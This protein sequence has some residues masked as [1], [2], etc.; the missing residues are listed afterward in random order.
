MLLEFV[1]VHAFNNS[2]VHG[3][4]IYLFHVNR[5]IAAQFSHQMLK[6]QRGMLEN[7]IEML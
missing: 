4:I 6:D 5:L 3:L 7:Y 1:F 2:F